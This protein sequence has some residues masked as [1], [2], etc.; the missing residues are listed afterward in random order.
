MSALVL[1]KNYGVNQQ[2]LNSVTRN[3]HVISFQNHT[4]SRKKLLPDKLILDKSVL[5][6][7]EDSP[8]HSPLMSPTMEKFLDS[9]N[10]TNEDNIIEPILREDPTRFVL[11][12]IKYHAL[13]AHYKNMFKC[14]WTAEEVD[15][16]NDLKDWKSLTDNER[17]FIKNVLAFFAGSDG[18]VIENLGERFLKEIQCPEGRSCYGYQLMIENV[19]SETYSL[20]IDIYIT[21]PQEKHRL[22]NAIHTVPCVGKK[23]KWALKWVKDNNSSFALRVVAFAVVEGIFFSGSFCAIFWLKQRGLMP[24]LTFSN[25]LISRDEGQHTDLAVLILHE[26]IKK[27]L[28]KDVHLLIK[29]AV[30]IEKEFITES[31]PCSLIGMNQASMKTYIEFVADRLLVQMGYDKLWN[32]KNPFDWM[33]LIS[34]RP[35]ANFFEQRVGQY[36]KSSVG[37]SV[38]E[39]QI[40]F[41]DSDDDF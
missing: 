35:K 12:P 7:V 40:N 4:I 3:S 26:L 16:S 31:L 9:L 10:E 18:I 17:H 29:E 15:F 28:Q 23:A 20:M 32:S 1:Q 22:L 5:N 39:N 21:D 2:Y 30:D 33:E 13:W 11:F 41:D 38:E 14:F 19:H 27:P 6:K 8:T 24:G 36:V 37:Q 34:L 25:E